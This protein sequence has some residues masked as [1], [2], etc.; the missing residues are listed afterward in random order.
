MTSCPR[1]VQQKP[2]QGLSQC[3]QK[4]EVLAFR[5]QKAETPVKRSAHLGWFGLPPCVRRIE[6]VSFLAEWLQAMLVFDPSLSCEST[7]TRGLEIWAHYINNH[8]SQLQSASCH[9]STY[10]TIDYIKAH[11]H[12]ASIVL[13]KAALLCATIL[14]VCL[15]LLLLCCT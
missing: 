6:V 1:S 3:Y 5:L 8:Q 11:I 14:L 12:H 10:S 9:I 7:V 4:H 2:P 15:Q 13:V